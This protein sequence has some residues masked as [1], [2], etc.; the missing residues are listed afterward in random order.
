MRMPSSKLES[1]VAALDFETLILAASF[2]LKSGDY[3]VIVGRSPS[4]SNHIS[5]L[6]DERG[7]QNVSLVF[8]SM[9]FSI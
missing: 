6:P 9:C 5:D 7:Y 1:N 2:I 3:Q 4:P 8:T